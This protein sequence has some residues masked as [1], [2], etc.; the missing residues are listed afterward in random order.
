MG[1]FVLG[2]ILLKKNIA[3][4]QLFYVYN[5]NVKNYMFKKDV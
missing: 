2:I 5:D 3:I 1:L 4:G